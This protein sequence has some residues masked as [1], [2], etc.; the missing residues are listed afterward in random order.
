MINDPTPQEK[1][2]K[3]YITSK[4]IQKRLNVNGSTVTRARRKGLLPSPIVVNG[5]NGYVWERELIKGNLDAWE[6]TLSAS[7]GELA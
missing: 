7:R 1:F 6:I 4:E 5:W 2:D 3:T